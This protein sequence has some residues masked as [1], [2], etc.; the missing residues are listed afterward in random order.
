MAEL[1]EHLALSTLDKRALGLQSAEGQGRRLRRLERAA[2]PA[3]H[4][5]LHP[6]LRHGASRPKVEAQIPWC[7]PA[8][9]RS[10]D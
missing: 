8:H 6:T 4:K 3:R 10:P 5:T 7:L 9:P 1:Q 2:K